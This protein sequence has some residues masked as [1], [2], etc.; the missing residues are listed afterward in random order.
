MEVPYGINLVNALNVSDEFVEDMTV[1]VCDTGID[2]GHPDLQVENV[3]GVSFVNETW[4]IDG[5]SHGTHVTGTI[6][7]LHNKF[8]VV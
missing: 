2:L 5:N 6:A 4:S 1:C 3:D 8:G 7:A